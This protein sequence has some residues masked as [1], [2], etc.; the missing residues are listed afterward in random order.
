M[1]YWAAEGAPHVRLSAGTSF[2]IMGSRQRERLWEGFTTSNWKKPMI[3][4]TT[5]KTL[6]AIATVATVTVTALLSS[7]VFAQHEH[8][9]RSGHYGSAHDLRHFRGTYNQA[10]VN[11]PFFGMPDGAA[12]E[13]PRDPS[14]VGGVDP[15]L[16][17]SAS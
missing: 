8:V 3:I 2:V 12:A 17:P 15:N 5:I 9:R 6:G 13:S 10:P 7:P 1:R 14:R 4:K 11:E 16:R